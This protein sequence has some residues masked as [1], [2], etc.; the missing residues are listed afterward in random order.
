M[1]RAGVTCG[2]NLGEKVVMQELG[3]CSASLQCNF[4][5]CFCNFGVQ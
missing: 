1:C 4:C 3:F 2:G 5:A